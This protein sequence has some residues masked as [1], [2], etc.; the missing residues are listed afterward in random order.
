[1]LTESNRETR[2]ITF[3]QYIE[4]YWLMTQHSK[5]GLRQGFHIYRIREVLLFALLR[6]TVN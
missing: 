1:M 3:Y 4:I 5:H 6:T 2:V